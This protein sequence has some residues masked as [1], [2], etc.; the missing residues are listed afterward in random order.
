MPITA[1]RIVKVDFDTTIFEAARIM[2]KHQ[3]SNLMLTDSKLVTSV[4][5]S[6]SDIVRQIV[7]LGLDPN[8]F[9]VGDIASCCRS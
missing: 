2:R 7:A 6:D 4:R 3:I 1:E 5:V 8:V 9:T